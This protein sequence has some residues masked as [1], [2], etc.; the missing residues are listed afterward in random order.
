MDLAGTIEP[1]AGTRN[2]NEIMEHTVLIIRHADKPEGTQEG[3]VNAMGVPDSRSLT[4][5]GWQRAGVWTELFVPSHGQVSTLPRPGAIFA[6]APASRAEDA[7][8]SG[9]KSRRPLETISPLA[10]K[11]GIKVDL[12][13]TK[14]G[15]V[16]LAETIS[17]IEGV[18]LVCWQ[19]EDIAAI[20]NALTPRP[21]DVP[22]NWPGHR[23]NVIF[24]FTR[25]DTASSWSF[26]QIVPVMLDGDMSEPLR[27]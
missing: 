7:E 12:R 17:S 16:D 5:R 10:A 21:R 19:H 26:E 1:E 18:V 15:E 20:A 14:G 25:P 3:G 2:R 11:L 8:G 4:P 22:R 23:F 9:S 13:F 6:S 24:K 27:G